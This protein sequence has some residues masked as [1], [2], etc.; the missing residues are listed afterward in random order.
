MNFSS[1]KHDNKQFGKCLKIKRPIRCVNILEEGNHRCGVLRSK[2]AQAGMET[3][4]IRKCKEFFR[5]P[6]LLASTQ[7]SP[8]AA[9][10]SV[11]E[12]LSMLK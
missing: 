4:L 8:L 6:P 7:I 12:G 9:P 3:A 10:F 11:I 2:R 1:E 5:R